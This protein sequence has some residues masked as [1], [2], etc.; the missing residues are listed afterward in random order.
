METTIKLPVDHRFNK[1]PILEAMKKF[2]VT[3]QELAKEKGCTNVTISRVL[4]G[5]TNSPEMIEWLCRRLNVSVSEVVS[6]ITQK[7]LS[8]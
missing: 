5:R 8:R 1:Q 7:N 3:A 2:G 6:P 4:N